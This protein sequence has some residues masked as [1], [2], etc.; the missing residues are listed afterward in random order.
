VIVPQRLARRYRNIFTGEELAGEGANALD[1]AAVLEH[2]PV[3]ILTS[4]SPS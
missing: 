3:A 4:G 1:V 2:F